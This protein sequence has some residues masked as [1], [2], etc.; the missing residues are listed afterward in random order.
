M[1]D[2]RPYRLT[3]LAMLVQSAC[4]WNIQIHNIYLTCDG[5]PMECGI[6]SVESGFACPRM[7]IRSYPANRDTASNLLQSQRGSTPA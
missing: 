7:P 5:G 6:V 1:I 2:I 3:I 4:Q